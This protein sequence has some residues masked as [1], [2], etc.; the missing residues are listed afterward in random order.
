M[1]KLILASAAL[2]FSVSAAEA[3]CTKKSLNGNW[4]LGTSGGSLGYVGSAAGGT[5]SFPSAA[6]NMT[7]TSFNS[8]SCKGSGSGTLSGTPATFTIN[9][10]RIP[11]SSQK[12]NQLFVDFTIGGTVIGIVLQRQ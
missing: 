7:I 3:I 9:S 5:F 6:L 4:S 12:P 2:A 1:K 8:K 11:G 10:E